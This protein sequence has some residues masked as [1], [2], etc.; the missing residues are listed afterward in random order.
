MEEDKPLE[1]L[2]WGRTRADQERLEVMRE[3]GRRGLRGCLLQAVIV[4][5]ILAYC[6]GWMDGR[7]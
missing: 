1:I 6:A 4:A 7:Y 3:Q 2:P 5:L